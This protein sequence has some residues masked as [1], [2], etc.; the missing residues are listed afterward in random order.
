[1]ALPALIHYVLRGHLAGGE[2]F[3]WGVWSQED[4]NDQST[5]DDY[6]ADVASWF[7]AGGSGPDG[8]AALI[9][10]ECG[11]DGVT[12]YSYAA[13]STAARLVATHGIA[14]PGSAA[15][16]GATQTSLVITTLTGVAGR[17]ARGRIYLPAMG[18]ATD[19]T[20]FL[21]AATAQAAMNAVAGLVNTGVPS[22]APVVVSRVGATARPVTQLRVDTRLDVQR[23][24]ANKLKGAQYF[25]SVT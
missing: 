4:V 9:P 18:A 23:G 12:L 11:Y 10:A 24:R 25:T 8:L 21:A 17:Q 22:L 3:N 6:A 20:G 19:G 15:F 13:G 2:V 7:S 14:L 1:M 16:H 5:L